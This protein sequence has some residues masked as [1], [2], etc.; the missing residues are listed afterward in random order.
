MHFPST[1]SFNY[2]KFS[3][4]IYDDYLLVSI[5]LDHSG[6]GHSHGGVPPPSNVRHLT[7][8]VN[9]NADMALGHN[10][11]DTEETDE[12]V[13]PKANQTQNNNKQ[14]PCRAGHD[15]GHLN[16]KGVFLHV[17]SDALGKSLLLY[18]KL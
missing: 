5:C 18:A 16:M 3:V 8:I 12:M 2:C 17:L 15:P 14:T 1:C 9:S 10:A 4:E 13:P 7:E 6:H 11:T